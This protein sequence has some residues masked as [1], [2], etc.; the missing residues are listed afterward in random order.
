MSARLHVVGIGLRRGWHEF[1]IGL[2]SPQDQSFFL[3]MGFGALAMLWFNR[4]E[5]LDGSTLTLP[6]VA[7]PSLLA[8]ILMFTIVIGPAYALALEREDGTLLRSRI[9]PYGLHGY[10]IGVATLTLVSLVPLLVIVLGG[11]ALLFEGAVPGD[12]GRWALIV[13]TL[14]LGILATLPLGFA[15]GSLVPRIQQVTTWGMLPIIL[16]AWI[17]GILGDMHSLWPWVQVLAQVFPLYWLGH[18]MRFAFL[19]E[20]AVAGE[21]Y[22]SWRIGPGIAVLAAWSVIGS[23]LAAVLVRRMARHQSGAAVAEARD[24][25]A[26]QYVR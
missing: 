4:D 17:S 12:L 6:Q 8:G 10:L 25:A 18:L 13:V 3:M 1:V 21:L 23:G 19:P 26:N 16:L 9:A 15:I 11:S 7:L 2:R 14:L 20:G 5:P 24:R 22:G